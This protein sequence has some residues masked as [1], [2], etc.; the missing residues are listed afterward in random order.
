MEDKLFHD[1][2]VVVDFLNPDE[3]KEM[4][5]G[6]RELGFGMDN[7]K[8]LRISVI[9]GSV[10]KRNEIFEKLSPVFQRTINEFLQNYKI[11]RIAVFD[12]LPGGDGI[13]IHQHANLVDESK[14][15]SLAIWIPLT[16]TKVDMGTLHVAKGSH[17]FTNFIRSYDDYFTVF[18]NVS[19]RVMKRYSIP[20]SLTAGQAVIFDDRLIHWSPPNISSRIRTAIQLEMVPQEAELAIY[21]RANE[22]EL[23]KYAIDE[24][25]YRVT[26][27]ATEKP[28][29][30]KF[31]G[32]LNQSNVRYGNRQFVK[33]MQAV[34]PETKFKSN[35]FER[36]FNL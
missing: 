27:M 30:L 13:R 12:K 16:E 3:L 28:D 19:A 29:N 32:K 35:F 7:E 4:Q 8:K 1:G 14:Y 5:K 25:T 15:R 34:N 23:L 17:L 11:I 6:I 31:I 26:A 2:Y 36:L 10:E 18:E 20:L 33:M 22:Q 21:Y 9:Q 24:K